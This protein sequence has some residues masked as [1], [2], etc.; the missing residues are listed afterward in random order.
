MNTKTTPRDFFLHLGAIVALVVSV[1]S[2]INLYFSIINYYFPDQ[3]AGNYYAN[4]IAWPISVLI[5]MVPL[6]Y[7]FEYMINKDITKSIEKAELW[8]RKWRVYLILFITGATIVGDIIA[9]I[10]VYLSG[11]IS[12]RFLYKILVVIV[13]SGII[14]AY[15]LI[16]KET[17]FQ[18]IN[19]KQKITKQ[20]IVYLGLLI[21]IVAVVLGFLVVGSPT[22]QRNLKFDAQRVN[23][24]SNIQWQVVG[25]WQQK[26]K[27]PTALA[28]LSDSING[29]SNPTDPE[30]KLDYKYSA[31]GV[32]NNKAS[33]ELCANF[34][35]ESQDD[36]GRGATYGGGGI[37][38][39][40]DAMYSVGYFG[41]EDNWKHSAGEACFT[42]TIDLDKYPVN[43]RK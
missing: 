42:R 1:V 23:D 17:T 39:A 22:K 38:I 40:T 19:S 3:L 33:F 20:V 6:L 15:Y 26:G 16:S 29:Y 12:T 13:I 34:A 24:L 43:P 28:E 25:Y 10:N 21:S 5:V 11:E 35:L 32:A 41:G 30:T 37:G 9:L 2:I 18:N 8:I 27:L 36:K 14:F 31:K 4:S 7:I